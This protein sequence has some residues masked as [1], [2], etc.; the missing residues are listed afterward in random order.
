[1]VIDEEQKFSPCRTIKQKVIYTDNFPIFAT[2]EGIPKSDRKVRNGV[3]TNTLNTNKPD[4]WQY[5]T[6]KTDS[7]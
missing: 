1:M 3:R 4:G 6:S 5:Y 7:N 2:F